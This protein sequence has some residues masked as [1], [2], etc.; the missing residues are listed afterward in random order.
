MSGARCMRSNRRPVIGAS[1]SAP[2]NNGRWNGLFA[3]EIPMSPTRIV[4]VA[5]WTAPN[6]TLQLSATIQNAFWRVIG[7]QN[8]VISASTER[9]CR[10]SVTQRVRPARR[11]SVMARKASK[12]KWMGNGKKVER[13]PLNGKQRRQIKP[14]TL[15]FPKREL[16]FSATYR[17]VEAFEGMP[18]R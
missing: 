8:E 14:S 6:R 1:A 3:T 15:L 16:Q 9:D 2:P 4:H 13:K 5:Y 11:A 10:E 17:K 12:R 7:W 18:K